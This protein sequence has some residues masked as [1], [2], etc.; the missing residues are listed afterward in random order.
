MMR[1][2]GAALPSS[3]RV[4]A[5]WE[6]TLLQKVKAKLRAA[7]YTTRGL[8]LRQEFMRLDRDRDGVLSRHEFSTAV[9]RRCRV[10][11]AEAASVFRHF[12][13]SGE[14]GVNIADFM[15]AMELG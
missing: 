1:L 14:R 5:G 9:R 15:A 2:H 10:S 8:D 13:R 12:N 6:P 7:A 3:S 4:L 11:E